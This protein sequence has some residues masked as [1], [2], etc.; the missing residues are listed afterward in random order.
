MH[1]FE[2]T[3]NLSPSRKEFVQ[4]LPMFKNLYIKNQFKWTFDEEG[5]DELILND[6]NVQEHVI[7]LD[8]IPG[9][10]RTVEDIKPDIFKFMKQNDLDSIRYP[11][12]LAKYPISKLNM[13]KKWK[14]ESDDYYNW[15]VDY[16]RKEE[17]G[18][19]IRL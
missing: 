4:Q 11:Y 10:R 16:N 8:K 15:L 12:E 19:K 14:K 1:T 9:K 18:I 7:T 5:K 13:G 2:E 17:S 6:F 3:K